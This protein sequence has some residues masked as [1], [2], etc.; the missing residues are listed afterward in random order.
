MSQKT[1]NFYINN[2]FDILETV[3]SQYGA[4]PIMQALIRGFNDLENVDP[5]IKLLLQKMIDPDTAEGVG[6]DVWGRIVAFERILVPVTSQKF[7]G[8][9]PTAGMTNNNLDSLNNAVFYNNPGGN[10]R[11]ADSAY[12]TYI[13]I[14]AMLNI[15]S[16]SLGDIN[17]MIKNLLPNSNIKIIRNYAMQLRVLVIGKLDPSG[18]RAL[19]SLP[20]IPTG[21]GLNIYI[22]ETPT[23]G[24]N[25]QNLQTF[26]NG[27]FATNDPI[28]S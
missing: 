15:S 5:A 12:R 18:Y 14:K 7:I 22:I 10:V 24:F 9:K 1:D 6:L 21:V 25:G 2:S 26:N 11:L 20:W 17:R 23:L 3:Q 13:F 27:T 19:I 16:S 8:F 4:S 28:Y